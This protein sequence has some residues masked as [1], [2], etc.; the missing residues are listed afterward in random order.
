MEDGVSGLTALGVTSEV[1]RISDRERQDI[2][3]A[4]IRHTDGR[5]PVIVGTT[6]PGL[7]TCLERCDQAVRAGASGFMV[8]PPRMPK[9]NSDYIRR[10]FATIAEKFDDT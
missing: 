9:V 1:A 8:S 2:L 5:V 7:D 6:G 10:H 4:S 3:E